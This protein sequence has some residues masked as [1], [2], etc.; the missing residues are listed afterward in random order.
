M[1]FDDVDAMP[2]AVM[3]DQ[4]RFVAVGLESPGVVLG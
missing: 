3:G 2:E 1:E 4:S